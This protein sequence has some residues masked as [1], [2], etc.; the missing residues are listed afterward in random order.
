MAAYNV[1]FQ[2]HQEDEPRVVLG[3]PYEKEEADRIAVELA[4][5]HVDDYYWVGAVR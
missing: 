5:T 4:A 3:G 2:G 1:F